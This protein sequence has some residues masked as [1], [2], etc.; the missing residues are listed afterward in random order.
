MVSLRGKAAG[1]VLITALVAGCSDDGGNA[2]PDTTEKPEEVAYQ[3]EEF[4][5]ADGDFY[6]TPDP[7]PDAEH[8]TLL[9]YEPRTTAVEG[10]TAWRIM[11]LSES[12]EG[13]PIT[14]TGVVIVPDGEPPAEGWKLLSVAHGTTGIGDDCTPSHNENDIYTL[15]AGEYLKAGYVVAITDYEGLGTPGIH[16]YLVGESEGRGVVDAARAARQLPDVTVGERYAVWGYSQGGHGAAWANEISAEWAPELELVG[17]VAGA[18][19]SE[20]AV[21]FQ[22]LGTTPLSP[23]FFF[24]TIAGYA[25]AY[26]DADP[27]DILTPAGL[28]L[29]EQ[30]D[31]GCFGMGDKLAGRPMSD[32]VKPDF[33]EAEAWQT[34]LAA[35]DPGQTAVDS[36][37][38]ILHSEADST[39]P[40]GLSAAMFGRMCETGQVVERRTYTKGHG[41]GEAVPDTVA[42]GFTWIQGLMSGEKPAISTCP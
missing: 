29:L 2:D 10:G 30:A 12:L 39:V 38:L 42:D 35:N 4:A 32:F 26:P 23:D 25:E 7:L 9:R 28:E 40:A 33:T 1:V 17:S 24:M 8:G 3:A 13:E 14:V 20:M 36:P 34:H 5:G 27:A 6:A 41:H 15:L 16:P 11:Y 21:I 22:A 31:D 37:L 18:P 19:P